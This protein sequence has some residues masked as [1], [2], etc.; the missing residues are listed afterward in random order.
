MMR[1]RKLFL[2]GKCG[3]TSPDALWHHDAD[4]RTTVNIND[5]ALKELKNLS[6][7][8]GRSFRATLDQVL[9]VG[10]A[11]SREDAPQNHVRI[12]PFR[13]GLHAALRESSLNQVYDR[14]EAEAGMGRP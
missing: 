3:L 12:K 1:E 14:I 11:H 8:S 4:M 5:A 13:L 7:R 10:I 6:H 2:E 9:A